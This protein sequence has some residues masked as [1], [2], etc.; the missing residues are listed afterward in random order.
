MYFK[1]TEEKYKHI[2][3]GFGSGTIYSYGC[4]LVSLVSGLSQKG[5]DFVPE[6]FNDLLKQNNA[7]VGEFNNYIDVERLN[8]ILPNIFISFKKVEPWP[9]IPLLDD[10]LK[11]N[12]IVVCKVSAIP[13]GGTKDATHFVLLTGK[14]GKTAIIHDPWKGIEEKVTNRWGQ[15]GNIFGLRIFEVR[16]FQPPSD[17]DEPQKRAL[18]VLYD[19]FNVLPE[20]DPLK[21]GSLEGYARA[22]VEEHKI[23][24]EV[25]DKAKILDGFEEKWEREW[26]LPVDGG[27]VEIE[28]EMNKLLVLEDSASVLREA[29]EKAVGNKFESDDKLLEILK[30]IGNERERLAGELT[31]CLKQKDAK[32]LTSFNFGK[33]L[34]RVYKKGMG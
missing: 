9:D 4:Y 3:L 7:F 6:G 29:I 13:I 5:Y 24:K 1:Q 34:I 17:P 23:H 18:K 27:I 33:Y 14:S 8:S 21:N 32:E 16:P 11:P 25:S 28:N 31:K 30:N 10:L 12:L 15:Y 26:N 20:S 2:Y 22:V 19:S